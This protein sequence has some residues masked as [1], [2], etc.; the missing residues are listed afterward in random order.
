MNESI[1]LK[2]DFL[3]LECTWYWEWISRSRSTRSSI[4]WSNDNCDCSSFV[5]N[6]KFRCH[7]RC[8]SWPNR[9]IRK[10]WSIIDSKRFL[11]SFSTIKKM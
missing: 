6:T 7:L 5:D 3:V 11:L 10:T 8:S 4:S 9:W 1:D 2:T